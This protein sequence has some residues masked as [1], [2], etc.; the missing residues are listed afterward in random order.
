MTG[1]K[2]QILPLFETLVEIV[3]QLRGPAGCPWD[4]EQTQSSLTQYAIEEAHELAEA[5]ETGRQ[6][7]V[8]EELG[9]FLFQVILQAQVAKDEGHF[10]LEQVIAQLNEK[11]VRRHPH[12]FSDMTL[13]STAEVWENWE[14]IK[15]AEKSN[16]KSQAQSPAAALFN[17]PKNLPA[18]LAAIKIGRKTE[19]WKFD[20]QT[21]EQVLEKV[22]EEFHETAEALEEF[23]QN[24]KGPIV[25]QAP[26]REHLEHEIG[27]LLFA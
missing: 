13:G 8:L 19:T 16:L 6:Q 5:I 17:Y 12:V 7:D 25:S 23:R 2:T 20:W 1:P 24:L 18:L 9:D 3:A 26:G 14:K 11:M 10:T 22:E 4:K 15:A 27:D 21:P